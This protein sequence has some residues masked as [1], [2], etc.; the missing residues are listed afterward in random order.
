[1]EYAR[2]MFADELYGCGMGY[3]V[4]Y[5]RSCRTGEAVFLSETPLCSL[6]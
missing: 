3:G 4:F 6:H 2:R 5:G 1:M